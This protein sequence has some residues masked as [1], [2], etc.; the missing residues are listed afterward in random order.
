MFKSKELVGISLKKTSPGKDARWE[1]Y[2]V[3]ALTLDEIDLIASDL[4][5]R[6]DYSPLIKQ[7]KS[8][9]QPS[10]LF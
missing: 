3:E 1:E 8:K 2:N 9:K 10:S 5:R 4:H 6:W 7:V